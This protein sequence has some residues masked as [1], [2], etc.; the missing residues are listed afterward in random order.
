MLQKQ[1]RLGLGKYSEL[2]DILIP[3]DN[4][5]R[6][7]LELVDFS[8]VYD[9]LA[10]KYSI[11]MGRSAVDPI[12]MFKYLYLKVRYNLS[13]RDL[14]ARAKTD[15]AMKFFLGLN[16]E[17]DVIHPSL[18]AKF[19]RQRLK[20]V[21]ILKQLISKTVEIAISNQVLEKN[22]IIVDATHTVARYNQ[23][24]PVETL[25]Q[26]SKLLRKRLYGVNVD[27]KSELPIKNTSNDLADEQQYVGKLIKTVKKM[28]QLLHQNGILEALH[29]LS[30]IQADVKAYEEY[31]SDSDAKVGHK[32]QDTA[33]FGYKTHLAMSENNIITAAVIT[34][35]EKGDGQYLS[36]LIEEA[37]ENGMAVQEVVGDHAYSGKRNLKY[38]K[39]QK[40]NLIARLTPAITNGHRKDEEKWDFNKDAGM[41]VCPAGHLAIRKARTG[42]KNQ[43]SNQ[44]MT[45]YFDIEKCQHCSLR[46]GCYKPDAKSKS[47][48]V[49]IKSNEH[50]QQMAFEATDYFNERI[51]TRYKIEAKNAE[52]KHEH[53]YDHSWSHDIE[54][55][56]LQGAI[57]LFCVNIKRIQML[58]DQKKKR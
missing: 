35:G 40:I 23:K 32:S 41:F 8:F 24:S 22:T 38:T 12:Q 50:Q 6:K 17:D 53:G 31:S 55:M 25:R 1:T 7:L 36:T 48:N 43:G 29:N 27:V 49:T 9:E 28:P 2:Y 10:T 56:T 42:K 44:V 51:K 16:P 15:M 58:F 34:S 46:E 37:N 14:V 39:K 21:N 13:D 20:D 26:S 30:E 4:E 18:L 3:A 45:Y 19:R 5:L 47:Y 11:D 54:A 57:T 33:F 52:L